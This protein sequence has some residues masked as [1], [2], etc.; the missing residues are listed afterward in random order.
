MAQGGVVK[1]VTEPVFWV[2]PVGFR[3]IIRAA[4]VRNHP[5]RL[6]QVPYRMIDAAEY[7]GG[8]H[9]FRLQP[10]CPCSP[11]A[12]AAQLL[13]DPVPGTPEPESWPL[14]VALTNWMVSAV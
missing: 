5:F 6:R 3:G 7:D 2:C 10:S 1:A 14:D 13:E 9:F 8:H 12:L 4:R 11:V